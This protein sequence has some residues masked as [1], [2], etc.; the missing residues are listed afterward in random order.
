M[1]VFRGRIVTLEVE[2]VELPNGAR[3]RMEIV[4]HPGG[5][6][7]VAIDAMDRVCLLR[8]YRHAVGDW[9]WEVPAGKIDANEPPLETA[10]RELAEE[11]GVA[12]GRWDSLG[13]TLTSPGVFT[14]RVHLWLA[15]HLEPAPAAPHDD[16]VFEI[17][18]VPFD[19]ALAR[20]LGGE[21]CDAKTVIAIAR[22]AGLLRR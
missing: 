18:W 10:R 11:A 8:Q 14:E 9:L 12:A 19:E 4:H 13:S 1:S 7:I 22:A 21:L 2:D 3:L 6:A 20:A 17:H 16:E 5:A 15:R